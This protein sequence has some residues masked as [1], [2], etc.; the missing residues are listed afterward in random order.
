M[1]N[2]LMNF[3]DNALTEY[4]DCEQSSILDYYEDESE[5]YATHDRIIEKWENFKKGVNN[6]TR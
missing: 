6:A 3:I 5:G 1:D 4:I 2:E